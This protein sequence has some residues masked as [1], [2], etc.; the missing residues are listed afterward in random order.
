MTHAPRSSRLGPGLVLLLLLAALV[1]PA[2]SRAEP[3]RKLKVL[4]VDGQNNHDWANTTPVMR[5]T[6]EKTGRFEVSVATSPPKNQSLEGFRPD[7]KSHDIVLSN[8]NGKDWSEA[9]RKDF[10]EFVRQGGGVVIVHAANNSFPRW[11]AFNEMIGLGGWGGRNEK[12]GPYLRLRDGKFVTDSSPGRGGSHGRQHP[13]V[14][15]AR[16]PE[17]PILKG[18]PLRWLHEKDELYDRLRGPARNVKVLA[19]SFAS[20]EH[21]G[22]GEHEPVLMTITWGKG[23]I[24]HTTLG[25]SPR[26]MT[27]VGFQTTLVRGAEWSAT[28]K[29]TLPVPENFPTDAEVVLDDPRESANSKSSAR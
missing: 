18:L 8:Y 22:S 20:K 7:F 25:H 15:E 14:V 28:G 27:C 23:R 4:I 9:T 6:L 10:E 3:P 26:S 17:H 11:K 13:F 24:F 19:T 29:V 5:A 16:A 12:S 1:V 21:R 2:D